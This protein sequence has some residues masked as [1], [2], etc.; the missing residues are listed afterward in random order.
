L[1]V[2]AA[3]Q[4]HARAFGFLI[5]DDNVRKNPANISSNTIPHQIATFFSEKLVTDHFFTSAGFCTCT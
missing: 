2:D 1:A 3:T 4:I 5:N